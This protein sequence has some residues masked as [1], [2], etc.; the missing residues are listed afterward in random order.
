MNPWQS[1]HFHLNPYPPPPPPPPQIPHKVWIIDCKSCGT[2]LTNR[3]MKAVL[4]LRPNVSLYS[5]DALPI[6]CS[7]HSASPELARPRATCHPFTSTPLPSR[8]CECLTQTLCC[9]GC[10]ST[11]GYMIVIPCARCTSSISATNRATNGHRFVFHSSEVVGTERHYI[12]NEPGVIPFEPSPAPPPIYTFAHPHPYPPHLAHRDTNQIQP[13][14][15]SRPQSPS[16]DSDYLATPPL[17]VADLSSA[18]SSS[19]DSFPF[20]QVRD[21]SQANTRPG[22][23]V[24]SRPPSNPEYSPHSHYSTPHFFIPS[25]SPP[26]H[27]DMSTEATEPAEQKELK[28]P[29]PLGAGDYIFWHHLTR[30]GEI[31][32]VAEDQRARGIGLDISGTARAPKVSFD[33]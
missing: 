27:T 21:D 33:R 20:P 23:T 2:F 17:E 9:H 1:H 19:A 28:P 31:P 18:S 22:P 8:T 13:E 3:G 26:N 24:T 10:G 11:V 14:L 29:K 32:A 30:S 15:H 7:A 4:L 5:S 16:I 25:Q 6:N 12:L